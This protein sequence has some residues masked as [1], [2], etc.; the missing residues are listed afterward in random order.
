MKIEADKS[1]K[2]TSW[3]TFGDS[4]VTYT[5]DMPDDFDDMWPYYKLIDGVL[6]YDA[7]KK[8]EE[9]ASQ[10]KAMRIAELKDQLMSTDYIAAKL[11]EATADAQSSGDSTALTAMLAKYSGKLTQR[12]A[13]REEIDTL[14]AQS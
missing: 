10:A 6:I 9:E 7:D 1:G 13:W 14:R 4:G 11:S 3:S 5:G 8:A 12:Q 2:I